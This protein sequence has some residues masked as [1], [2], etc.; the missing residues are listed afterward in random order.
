MANI[1][2][3]LKHGTYC[4]EH[5]SMLMLA[6]SSKRRVPHRTASIAADSREKKSLLHCNCLV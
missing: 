2:G 5:V 6:H 1:T 4:C 3:M